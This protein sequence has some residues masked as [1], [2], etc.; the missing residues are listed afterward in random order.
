MTHI[1]FTNFHFGV[2]INF[3]NQN[4]ILVSLF[5]LK[6]WLWLRYTVKTIFFQTVTFCRHILTSGSV[7]KKKKT[8]SVTFCR[9]ILTFGSVTKK[10]KKKIKVSHFVDKLCNDRQWKQYFFQTVTFCRQILTLDSV[11]KK[12]K[13]KTLT[14]T[15]CR[16]ILLRMAEYSLASLARN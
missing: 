15:F 12:K 1:L 14:V 4:Y 7:T 16:Q 8:S 11:T 3:S 5:V 9:Q 6:F 2:N 10:K 13:K